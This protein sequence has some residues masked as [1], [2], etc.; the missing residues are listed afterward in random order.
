MQADLSIKQENLLLLFSIALLLIVI[1]SLFS[2][3]GLAHGCP[4]STLQLKVIYLIIRVV[5]LV[6]EGPFQWENQ[7]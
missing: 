4:S 6:K 2:C 7:L 3:P 1:K 5:W